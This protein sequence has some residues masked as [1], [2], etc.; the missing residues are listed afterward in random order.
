MVT[1][2]WILPTCVVKDVIFPF[3]VPISL[4]I[5]EI[6][7][8]V[9]SKT[10]LPSSHTYDALSIGAS[11]IPPLSSAEYQSVPLYF[12]TYPK[13]GC[14]V[15]STSVN[16]DNAWG[17]GVAFS[18]FVSHVLWSLRVPFINIMSLFTFIISFYNEI[19]MLYWSFTVC[20]NV[21]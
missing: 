8:V 17:G 7:D 12:N 2:V 4:E 10:Q 19:I 6:V 5:W 15:K 3:I 14:I 9:A 13:T 21:L 18:K 16:W 20:D 11:W 1:S